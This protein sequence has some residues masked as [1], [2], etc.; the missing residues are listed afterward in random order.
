MARRLVRLSV[1]LIAR[2][3]STLGIVIYR[4]TRLLVPV[5]LF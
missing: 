5:R 4:A 1:V 2:L 3:V